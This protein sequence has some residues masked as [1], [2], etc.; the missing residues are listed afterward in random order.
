MIISYFF[1]LSIIVGGFVFLLTCSIAAIAR[2]YEK[3]LLGLSGAKSDSEYADYLQ[4]NTLVE[5]VH[6]YD[7]AIFTKF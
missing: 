7:H 2:M 4:V 5:N 1:T 3:R 6:L